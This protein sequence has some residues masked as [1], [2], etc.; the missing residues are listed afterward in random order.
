MS[1]PKAELAQRALWLS[2]WKAAAMPAAAFLVL[3]GIS[4]GKTWCADR[5]SV[6]KVGNVTDARVIAAAPQGRG[7]PVLG[8]SF[9]S[10]HYSPLKQINAASV[11]RLGLAWVLNI[12]SPMGLDT[13]PIVVDGTIYATGSLDRV[14]GVDAASGRLL[15]QF[16]PHV[17]LS[18]MRNSWAARSNR[19]VAVYRGKVYFGTGDCRLFALDAASGKELWNVPVCVDTTQTGITGAPTVGDGKVYIGYN[20]SD[21]GVR[22]SLVAFDADTGRLAWRFWNVPGNP[23]LGF[24]N[25]ALRMAAKTWHGD[26]WWEVGGGDVWDSITYDPTTKYVIYG[27]AGATPEPLYGDRANMKVS[28]PRLFAGCIVAVRA[29]TGAYVWHYQTSIHT[30]NFHVLV[31]DLTIGGAKRHVVMTVP[32][33]GTFFLLDAKTGGLIS[34]KD[35]ATAHAGSADAV[36]RPLAGHNWWPMSYNPI[37]RLVYIPTYD[38]VA[39]PTGY[40]NQATGRLIA[41]NPVTE[42][43]R[44]TNPQQLSTNSGVLSTAGNLVFQG[45]GTGEFDAYAADT[46]KK[47]WSIETGSAIDSVPVT[48]MIGKDQYVLMPVG[49]GSASRQF[50]PVSTMATPESKLGPS[51]LLAFRLGGKMPFPHPVLII[52]PVPRPPEQ[53]AD[54]ATVERG[55]QVF[56]KFMC[57]DCHSPE[58][59]GSGQ[60]R[61]NGTIPDLRYMPPEVH[62]QFLAIVLGGTHRQ[63][64]MPGFAAGPGFPL[65]ETKMSLADAQALHAYIV[66]LQWRAYKK[67]NP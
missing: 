60:W 35:L 59:D 10:R 58:A 47:L 6:T 1:A 64:G 46:G 23:S 50:G 33:N 54:A 31:T 28:G 25:E 63:D 20:G 2:M 19:G 40:Q 39:K 29:D 53:T 8:G 13:E 37:T 27:T 4:A 45:Q 17:R 61:L 57:G 16:D 62:Q 42:S 30:E 51:R 43:A 36:Q 32:R 34:K 14:Y 48:Y 18:V 56:E 67:D 7:W 44:W 38:N 12:D 9:G 21:T 22:G 24:E 66:S 55:Q 5:Q 52:P 11:K 3:M 26:Q 49:L 41:W 15:W 65:V